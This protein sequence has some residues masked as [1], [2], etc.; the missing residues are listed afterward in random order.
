VNTVV[1]HLKNGD[2]CRLRLATA[3]LSWIVSEKPKIRDT[4]QGLLFCGILPHRP[5]CVSLN[6]F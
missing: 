1:R 4:S 2:F 5:H 3:L 6:L